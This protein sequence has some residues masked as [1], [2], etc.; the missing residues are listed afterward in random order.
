[1]TT[2][3]KDIIQ[4]AKWINEPRKFD[5]TFWMELRFAGGFVMQ[6]SRYS[7]PID[8]EDGFH[9]IALWKYE[10]I[11]FM[12]TDIQSFDKYIFDR[13]EKLKS[14]ACK[15]D[16]IQKFINNY[17]YRNDTELSIDEI[18]NKEYTTK[19]EFKKIMSSVTCAE[20]HKIDIEG[21]SYT[22]Y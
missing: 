1:M 4:P 19:E 2:Y 14:W 16:L 10:H 3:Y 13:L 6:P 9:L 11:K 7:Y 5:K 12:Y 18:F 21:D 8:L 17:N 22:G 20:W 15:S